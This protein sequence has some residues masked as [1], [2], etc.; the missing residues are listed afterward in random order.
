MKVSLK[1]IKKMLGILGFNIFLCC[2]GIFFIELIFGDWLKKNNLNQLNL[3]RSREISFNIQ[4]LYPYHQHTIKYRRDQYGL[5]GDFT[6]P[7]EIT[8]LT[9]GGSTTDQRYINEGETW[10]D[11]LSQN[12]THLGKCIIVA[13]AGVD[14]QSSI[15]H[16]KNFDWWFPSIPELHPQY[17]LFYI[18]IND[19][20]NDIESF[21]DPLAIKEM[22]HNTQRV[23]Q[24]IRQNS[25]VFY[26]V[27]TLITIYNALVAKI[28][29]GSVNFNNINWVTTPILS[30]DDY[31]RLMR[32][33]LNAYALRLQILCDKTYKMGAIPIFVTQPTR[34]YRF[35]HNEFQGIAE[36]PEYFGATINGIDYYYMMRKLD[37][38]TMQIC[39]ENHGICIDMDQEVKLWQDHDFYDRFH[40]TPTG[41]RKIGDYL[42]N[43]LK[44]KL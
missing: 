38:V 34:N 10:Q 19:F 26:V 17:I 30:T 44:G 22:T 6:N 1:T 40:M 29:H 37:A 42:F 15:G 18:G 9:V 7:S 35:Y 23:I 3:I 27:R 36:L 11:V 33:R 41:T 12:F 8:M 21:Y 39:Q 25:A 4:R 28:D 2:I 20:Y 14:G 31:E 5:R 16:A 43:S 24:T 32:P 13:N